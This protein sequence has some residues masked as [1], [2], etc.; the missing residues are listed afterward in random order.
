MRQQWIEDYGS[1]DGYFERISKINQE[2]L[3]VARWVSR[4]AAACLNRA[5]PD[6]QV[7][8]MIQFYDV[9][10]LRNV[11]AQPQQEVCSAAVCG[12]QLIRMAGRD[13]ACSAR[14]GGTKPA[15]ACVRDSD[16]VTGK[17]GL[18]GGAAV[19]GAIGHHARCR[20]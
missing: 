4:P 9:L 20:V 5:A 2:A 13:T 14:I 16:C 12:S 7:V 17:T 8:A 11:T 15:A 6:V 18:S 1:I 19:Q 3:V 10:N